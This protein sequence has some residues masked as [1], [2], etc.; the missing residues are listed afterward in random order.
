MRLAR[1]YVLVTVP[2]KPDDNPERIHLFSNDDLARLFADAKWVK[3][4]GVLNHRFAMIA[5]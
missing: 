2:S 1:Q 4:G 3:F 5:V